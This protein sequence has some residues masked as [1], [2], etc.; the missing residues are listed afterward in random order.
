MNKNIFYFI[1]IPD[2]MLFEEWMLSF[3]GSIDFD[4]LLSSSSSSSDSLSER[5]MSSSS[6]SLSARRK[7]KIRIKSYNNSIY[8]LIV[9]VE[10]K[11]RITFMCV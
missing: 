11:N 2:C 7:Y 4:L 8:E 1:F 5:K 9:V 6:S 3:S 10:I